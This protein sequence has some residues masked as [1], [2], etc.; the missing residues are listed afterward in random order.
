MASLMDSTNIY[1]QVGKHYG[2]AAVFFVSMAHPAQ[3]VGVLEIIGLL[4][5]GIVFSSA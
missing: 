5:V 2:A 1:D 3:A 4:P